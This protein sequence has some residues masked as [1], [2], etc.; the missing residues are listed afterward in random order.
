MKVLQQGKPVCGTTSSKVYP[1]NINANPHIIVITVPD[2]PSP[3]KKYAKP[4]H[5]V[6]PKHQI[7]QFWLTL[8]CREVIFCCKFTHFLVYFLQ[9]WNVCWRT[10]NDKYENRFAYFAHLRKRGSSGKP[11]RVW[12]CF[13]L[14]NVLY[15]E[16]DLRCWRIWNMLQADRLPPLFKLDCSQ[17]LNKIQNATSTLPIYL[18]GTEAKFEVDVTFKIPIFFITVL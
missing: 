5:Q 13:A 3:P 11:V 7:R 9:L 4:K 18:Y 16:R 2:T 1:G 15:F 6:Q 14:G 17:F 10:I 12:V 8:I